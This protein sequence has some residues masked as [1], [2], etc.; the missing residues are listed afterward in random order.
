MSEKYIDKAKKNYPSRQFFC[1]NINDFF[2]VKNDKDIIF[3]FLGVFH[4]LSDVEIV[5]LL[6]KLDEKEI[7]YKIFSM[8]G[9]FL[10]KQHFIS[11][12]MLKNDRGKYVRTLEGYK[13]ILNDFN[14]VI[15]NDLL[16]IPYDGVLG[17]KNFSSE[18]VSLFEG[19]LKLAS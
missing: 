14:F 19:S 4:H 8:D 13:K 1:E 10:P 16:R 15:R 5:N 11:K 12:L 9:I 3:L 6:K 7:N 17:F 18:E 2:P